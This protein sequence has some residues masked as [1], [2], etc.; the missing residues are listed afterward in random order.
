MRCAGRDGD[1]GL[2]E[3]DGAGL[4]GAR[5]GIHITVESLITAV[6][7]ELAVEVAA[8]AAHHAASHERAGVI[9][10]R[11]HGGGGL[12]RSTVLASSVPVE[13]STAPSRRSSIAP[14]RVDRCR[15]SP[16]SGLRRCPSARNACVHPTLTA[17]ALPP[18]GTV[19]PRR[20]GACVDGA[21]EATIGGAGAE[22]AVGALPQ[23]RTAAAAQHGAAVEVAHRDALGGAAGGTTVA[24]VVAAAVSTPSRRASVARAPVRPLE[25]EPQQRTSPS[26]STAQACRFAHVDLPGDRRAG[27]AASLLGARWGCSRPGGQQEGEGE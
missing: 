13:G 1:G 26:R 10:A 17:L 8:P 12:A 14:E 11:A 24:L 19:R 25:P 2:A 16:S 23:Q 4:I 9:R 7:A 22:H 15:R 21:V 3:I 6:G 20:C 18:K 27:A 5:G